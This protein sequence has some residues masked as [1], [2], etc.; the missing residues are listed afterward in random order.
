MYQLTDLY[1]LFY[2]KYVKNYHGEDEHY[3]SHRQMDISSWEGY[4]FEQVCL[5]HIPQIKRKLGL[6]AFCRI[7]ARGRAVLLRM[8]RA[9]SNQGHR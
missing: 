1:S 5:H 6:V 4:A 3:W 8:Q 9:I 2:L 7:S